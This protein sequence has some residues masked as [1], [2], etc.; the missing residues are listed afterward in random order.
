MI[1][2]VNVLWGAMVENADSASLLTSLLLRLFLVVDL[3]LAASRTM[4]QLKIQTRPR[5]NLATSR[6]FP[7][8][9]TL[10]DKPKLT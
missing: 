9:C 4:S 5:R 2:K 6:P 1:V 8:I 7:Q 10:E 3:L